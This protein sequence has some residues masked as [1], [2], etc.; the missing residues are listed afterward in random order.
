MR[1]SDYV[2][3]IFIVALVMISLSGV[4]VHLASEDNYN[5]TISE[6]FEGVYTDSTELESLISDTTGIGV[7]MKEGLETAKDLPDDYTDPKKQ[8][9]KVLFFID[10][11]FDVVKN[12]IIETGTL[13]RIPPVIVAVVLA[14]LIFAIAFAIITLIFNRLS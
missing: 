6:T 4:F 13:L 7:D 14:M 5:I 12:M 9:I 8:R 2:G 11:A 3:A 1:L 10:G